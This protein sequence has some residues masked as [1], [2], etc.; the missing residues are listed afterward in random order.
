MSKALLVLLLAM[1]AL[2]ACNNLRN[3]KND[4]EDDSHDEQEAQ[5]SK[6]DL[7]SLVR[8]RQDIHQNPEPGFH[9]FRTQKKL[10]KY[11]KSLGV[12][13]S[14]IKKIATTGLQVDI[15]GRGK[16]SGEDRVIAFR[17]DIDALDIVEDNPTLPYR[18]TNG[19]AHACGHDGHMTS[20]LG[21]AAKL[22]DVIG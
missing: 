5:A 21:F 16:A 7:E 17:A 20:T 9:E 18:S 4:S 3:L 11:L 10:I 6:F 15:A 13:G 2:A 12:R 22:M 8:F 14:S 1:L 19:N